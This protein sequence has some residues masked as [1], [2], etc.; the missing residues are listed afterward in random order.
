MDEGITA[1]EAFFNSP[2]V[3]QIQ[4]LNKQHQFDI[5]I[6]EYFNTPSY[7]P[8]EFVGYSDKMNFV[9]RMVNWI[10]VHSCKLGYR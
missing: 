1:C 4:Q 9:K 7:I 3:E 2:Y 5:L 10:T 6:T 8:N